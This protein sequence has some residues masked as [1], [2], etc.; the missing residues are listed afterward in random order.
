MQ[1]GKTTLAK[2]YGVTARGGPPVGT[3]TAFGIGSVT[4]QLVS[5]CV[6][7]LA[8]DG[9]LSPEDKV[10]RY[11]PELTRAGEITLYDLMT[12]ES[13]YPDFYP[14]DFLDRRMEAPTTPDAILKTYAT[15]KLDFDPGTRWSYSNT[16]YVLLGRV[17]EKVSGEPFGAFLG[18]R[19]LGPLGMAHTYFEPDPAKLA[20]GDAR[21]GVHRVRPRGGGAG[22]A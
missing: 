10:A 11:F 12:H 14:L 19:I 16:G 18:R 17:V 1:D 21:A 15:G 2:G 6:L 20:K 4:K 3:D 22:E 9:K 7:L 13:G 8:D 5:A